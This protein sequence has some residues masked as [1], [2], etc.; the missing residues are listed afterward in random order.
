MVWDPPYSV[1]RNEIL[2]ID[3]AFFNSINKNQDIV[4]TI[5]KSN[6]FAA[7]DLSSYGWTGNLL[8]YVDFF[9]IP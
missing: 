9:N 2:I 8:K 7:V 6:K 3:L 4:I 1:Q 5:T